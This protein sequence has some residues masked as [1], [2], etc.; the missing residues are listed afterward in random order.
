M[1]DE[2]SVLMV[3][4]VTTRELLYQE[5]NATSVAW[6]SN[7]EVERQTVDRWG[8]DSYELWALRAPWRV[9]SL[10]IPELLCIQAIHKHYLEIKIVRAS[11]RLSVILWYTHH[12]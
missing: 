8:R 3:Y 11:P 9:F 6:N 7:C 4:D 10:C 2:N 5:P 1:V 12:L